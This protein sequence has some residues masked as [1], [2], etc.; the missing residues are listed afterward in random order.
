MYIYIYIYKAREG[1]NQR[2]LVWPPMTF[3]SIKHGTIFLVVL[4][5]NAAAGPMLQQMRIHRLLTA[6]ASPTSL[7]ALACA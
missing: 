4:P 5:V 1:F 3:F 7:R 2:T 6:S